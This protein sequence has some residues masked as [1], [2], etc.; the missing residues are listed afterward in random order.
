MFSDHE[1][2]C[3]SP[4]IYRSVVDI[5]FDPSHSLVLARDQ[6][7]ALLVK[8]IEKNKMF[9]VFLKVTEGIEDGKAYI[10]VEVWR[11]APHKYLAYCLSL[12]PVHGMVK[13][14]VA[15]I[16]HKMLMWASKE[17]AK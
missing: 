5:S 9:P 17:K 14:A 13:R 1:R 10:D 11:I 3:G 2:L 15:R 4:Q 16:A 6:M 12:F 7:A 8:V